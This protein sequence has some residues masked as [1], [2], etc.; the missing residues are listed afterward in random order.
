M[1]P[2][3]EARVRKSKKNRR[4]TMDEAKGRQAQIWWMLGVGVTLL[5]SAYLQSQKVI[6][7]QAE[8]VPAQSLPY[9][10]AQSK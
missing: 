6:E 10:Q 4:R 9:L 5:I 8:R 7:S 3:A 2:V 1:N